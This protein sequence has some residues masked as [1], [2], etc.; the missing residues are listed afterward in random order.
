VRGLASSSPAAR[1]IR[2]ALAEQREG[3]RGHRGHGP[4]RPAQQA[5]DLAAAAGA[6]PVPHR[7]LGD[8]QA[9][10][11]RP[12]DHLQRPTAAPVGHAERQQ[13]IEAAAQRELAEESGYRAGRLEPVC[14]YHTSKSVMDE[15]A[16]LFLAFDLARATNTPGPDE[17]ESFQVRAHR[18]EEVLAMVDTGE[19][20][21]S[22]T[23]IAVLQAARRRAGRG[24]ETVTGS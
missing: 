20:V 17:T 7:D 15:T 23:I 8:P 1:A 14:V 21:D 13:H 18:F 3:D 24:P 5:A 22:M 10:R 2:P 11:A 12:A 9:D 19:I 16:H 4:D 6:G